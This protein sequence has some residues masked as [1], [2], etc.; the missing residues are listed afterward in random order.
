MADQLLFR[1]DSVLLTTIKAVAL[2]LTFL[3]TGTS[4]GV[5]VIG[6]RCAICT[7]SDPHDNRL[8]SSVLIEHQGASVVIDAGPDFRQQ[9]L[10]ARVNRL[11]AVV[12]TH[13]HKDHIGGLDDIRAFNYLNHGPVEVWAA[14]D[15][16]ADIRRDFF[17]AFAEK[18]YSGVPEMDLHTITGAPF[19]VAGLTFTPIPVLHHRL[20]V[21]GFRVGDLAYITDCN[22]IPESSFGLL[23]GVE[24]LIVNALRLKPHVSHFSLDEAL[25]AIGRVSPREAWLTH[26]SHGL[27]LHS[28]I[29]KQ[30]P[31]GVHQAWDGLVVEV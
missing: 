8:R 17:Y 19:E 31:D 23:E 5:P 26:I 28:E 2:K 14:A 18:R 21:Y 24:V 15:V 29:G 4:N 20:A 3:G 13:G 7:S 12:I 11:D 27:G 9:M 25:E 6:C 1:G 16:Q 22:F 30:L 10:R